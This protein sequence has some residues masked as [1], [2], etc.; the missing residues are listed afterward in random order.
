M[1]G[2]DGFDGTPGDA[3]PVSARNRGNSTIDLDI[4]QGMVF[5]VHAQIG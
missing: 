3:C 1:P 2:S 4:G 5:P